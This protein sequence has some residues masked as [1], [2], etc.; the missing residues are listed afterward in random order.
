MFDLIG[1]T[2]HFA[3]KLGVAVTF[4]VLSTACSHQAIAPSN[5]DS[6]PTAVSDVET[7]EPLAKASPLA[8]PV[9][10]TA[11]HR[12][13]RHA[14][15]KIARR[16]HKAGHAK[17]AKNIKSRQPKIEKALVAST[18]AAIPA[19]PAGPAITIPAPNSQLATLGVV[20]EVDPSV[21]DIWSRLAGYWAYALAALGLGGLLFIAPRARRFSKPKRKLVYNG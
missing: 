14:S 13:H 20:T 21:N 9:K 7:P 10:K 6:M 12:R 1:K 4:L 8:Q 15:N 16:G 3:T 18:V 19:P 17:I 11:A 2:S 5:N